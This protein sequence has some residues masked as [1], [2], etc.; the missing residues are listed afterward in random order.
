MKGK[1][2]VFSILLVVLAVVVGIAGI[3]FV[4]LKL[5][6]NLGTANRIEKQVV[7]ETEAEG[8]TIGGTDESQVEEALPEIPEE[9][10]PE[11]QA[12]PEEDTDDSDENNTEKSESGSGSKTGS[13]KWVKGD[14]HT[15]ILDESAT[16]VKVSK[17]LSIATGDH[18]D[19]TTTFYLKLSPDIVYEDPPHLGAGGIDIDVIFIAAFICGAVYMFSAIY[20]HSGKRSY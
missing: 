18:A 9:E 7:E 19:M 12:E 3:L 1:R 8:S 15:V 20:S 14:T 13:Q 16:S 2:R 5:G 10:E 17:E 6:S 4:V 11:E